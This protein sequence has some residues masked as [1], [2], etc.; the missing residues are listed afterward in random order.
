MPASAAN[1][2]PMANLHI[3]GS[4]DREGRRVAGLALYRDV[5]AHYLTAC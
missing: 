5:A 3:L 1:S 4:P 2:M